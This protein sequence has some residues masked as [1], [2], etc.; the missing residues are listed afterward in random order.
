M[1]VLSGR[2]LLEGVGVPIL[3]VPSKDYID[4]KSLGISFTVQSGYTAHAINNFSVASGAVLSVLGN[5]V[6]LSV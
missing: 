6:V 5:V 2:S 3:K 4:G 1:A